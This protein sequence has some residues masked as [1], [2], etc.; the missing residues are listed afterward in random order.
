MKNGV[1]FV[2]VS[3]GTVVNTKDLKKYVTKNKFGGVGLDVIGDKDF[4]F[5]N[6][7]KK[8][9]NVIFS[10]HIAGITTDMSRRYELL[11]RNIKRY[12]NNDDLIN[13]V[14]RKKGY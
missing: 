5:R 1:F 9:S 4:V 13:L 11:L 12:L 3:R 7:F 6:P 8:Y 2:N 10:N 14:D